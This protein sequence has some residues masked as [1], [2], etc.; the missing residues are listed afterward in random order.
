[1]FLAAIPLLIGVLIVGTN[2]AS[3][4]TGRNL[5]ERMYN[6]VMS[7]LPG[8]KEA[9]ARGSKAWDTRTPAMVQELK[10][11]LGSPVTGDGFAY[12]RVKGHEALGIT[13]QHNVFTSA[14][15]MAG[16]PGLLA[17]LVPLVAII[18]VGYRMLRESPDPGMIALGGLGVI[19]GVY[20]IVQGMATMA[21]NV[22]RPA[23][24][25][26]FLVGA[27]LRARAMQLS[28]PREE[29]YYSS[30]QDLA[31]LADQYEHSYSSYSH[32]GF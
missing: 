7:M 14:L 16:V 31:A 6:R 28:Q 8:Q 5:N 26:G 24:A 32:D 1:M 10:I 23:M 17:Y 21:F 13:Y 30:E 15:A 4:V 3:N 27:V 20:N 25:V 29:L 11:W 9:E 19:A 18:V 22:Q 2:I 12:Y